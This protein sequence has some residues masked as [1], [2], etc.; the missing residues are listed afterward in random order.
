MKA[1]SAFDAEIQPHDSVQGDGVNDDGGVCG[2]DCGDCCLQE[3]SWIFPESKI[4][5]PAMFLKCVAKVWRRK[6]RRKW[7]EEQGGE[8]GGKS[9][10]TVW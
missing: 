6:I 7:R 2:A 9:S 5:L 4:D 8:N 10:V 3:N 1:A